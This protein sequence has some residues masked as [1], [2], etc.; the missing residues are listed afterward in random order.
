MLKIGSALQN[1]IQFNRCKKPIRIIALLD[2]MRIKVSKLLQ[3]C[4]VMHKKKFNIKTKS[5]NRDD[6]SPE[7]ANTTL[8]TKQCTRYIKVP[9]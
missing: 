6:Q 3:Q 7:L 5:K 2:C 9:K 8:Y 4:L 1:L